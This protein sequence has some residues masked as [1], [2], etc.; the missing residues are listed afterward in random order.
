[1]QQHDL[2]TWPEYFRRVFNG[3]KMF[4]VR[5]NDR[6]FQI[7]DFVN[8]R[9]YDPKTETYTGREI[10]FRIAYILHGGEFGIEKGYCVMQLT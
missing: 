1:M 4:E 8:L 6:D 2:K 9:E 7:G 5:K 10:L 3:Q